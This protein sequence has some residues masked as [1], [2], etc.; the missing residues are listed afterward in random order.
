MTDRLTAGSITTI[1]AATAGQSVTGVN[2]VVQIMGIKAMPD[3]SGNERYRCQITDGRESM[4][5]ISASSFSSMFANSEI[6]VGSVISLTS[7]SLN[8]NGNNK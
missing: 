7:F 1:G 4:F 5:A 6:V 8:Q 3:G 2:H